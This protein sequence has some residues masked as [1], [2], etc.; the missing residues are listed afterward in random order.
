MVFDDPDTYSCGRPQRSA[1]SICGAACR[2]CSAG[3]VRAD[4][5][6]IGGA[7]RG[8]RR[9]RGPAAGA[10]LCAAARHGGPPGQDVLRLQLGCSSPALDGEIR[11]P[12]LILHEVAHYV[13]WHRPS[14]EAAGFRRR[15]RTGT[16]AAR[17]RRR[18]AS[19]DAADAAE[20]EAERGDGLA[21]WGFC[22]RRSWDSRRWPRSSVRT[23]S[24][25]WSA[26]GGG[27]FYRGCSPP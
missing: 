26:F 12:M 21:A 14:G 20:R 15:C 22:G 19:R 2:G 8:C 1:R 5:S 17:P 25:G 27:A 4:P 13:L 23:G 3:G 6:P 11:R 10:G 18:R 7:G 24:K 9:G 16:S